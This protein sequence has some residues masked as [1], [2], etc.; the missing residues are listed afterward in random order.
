MVK[1]SRI[2]VAHLN[3]Y[4]GKTQVL[5]DVN[6]EFESGKIYGIVGRN[7]SGKTVLFKC[8]CGLVPITSGTVTVRGKEVGK[9]VGI[10]DNMGII[11]ETPGFLSGYN[12]YKNLKF[13]ADVKKKVGNERIREVLNLVGL[14][15][16]DKKKVA[17]YSMGMRQRLGI[18][19]AIMEYPDILILDEPMNGLDNRGV[20]Q[21][22]ELFLQ[23]KEEGTLIILASHNKEDISCL[24]DTVYEMDDGVLYGT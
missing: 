22:R 6:V 15:A 12:G 24:C 1:E 17:K 14:S 2:V 23:L 16:D 8:I 10:P 19:Q 5:F 21:M 18:A 13:L 9:D 11:L 4:F 20:E 7:G 3:K